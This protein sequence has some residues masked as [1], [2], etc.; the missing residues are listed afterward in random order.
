MNIYISCFCSCLCFRYNQ[1]AEGTNYAESAEILYDTC[2]S[3]MIFT[4]YLQ[5][6]IQKLCIVYLLRQRK[7][8]YGSLYFL[9]SIRIC[10][11][12]RSIQIR[13]LP[14]SQLANITALV[15]Y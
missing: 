6:V 9:G 14:F 15:V 12:P 8:A 4:F 2:Y 13:T 5:P 7:G 11:L 10:I 1:A 3:G